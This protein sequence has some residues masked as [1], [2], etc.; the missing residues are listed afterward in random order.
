MHGV[1]GEGKVG[2]EGGPRELVSPG[3]AYRCLLNVGMETGREAKGAEEA[4]TRVMGRQ[5]EAAK[6]GAQETAPVPTKTPAVSEPV[7]V[8][9]SAA[10]ATP[11]NADGEVLPPP[12]LPAP[13]PLALVPDEPPPPLPKR[14]LPEVKETFVPVQ[15][16]RRKRWGLVVAV[17]MLLLLLGGGGYVWQRVQPREAKAMW[18]RVKGWGEE[19]KLYVPPLELPWKKG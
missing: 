1:K 10:V 2:A 18:M 15:R 14:Y 6:A 12:P 11:A 8:S 16:R 4:R 13:D 7:S 19:A 3:T 9:E 17:M 5:R